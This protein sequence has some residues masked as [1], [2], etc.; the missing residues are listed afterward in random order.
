[1]KA[2]LLGVLVSSAA[3]G[4]T[5]LKADLAWLTRNSDAVVV[6]KVGSVQSRFTSDQKRI[7]TDTEISVSQMLKGQTAASV[8]VMQPGGEVGD[9]GQHVSGVARFSPGEEVVVFLEKRG[10]RYFVTGLGQGKYRLERAADG[11]TYAMPPR[12]LDSELVDPITRQPT[13]L[14]SEPILFEKFVQQIVTAAG[15]T[16]PATT[17]TPKNLG[18]RP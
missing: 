13:S 17:A 18:T 11:K 7:M 6:G 3:F 4:T 5:L 2:F 9:V 14:S 15:Q 16:A 8:V 10:D 1:M 12:D